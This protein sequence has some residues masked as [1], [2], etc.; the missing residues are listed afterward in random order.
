[1]K[2]YLK[3]RLSKRQRWLLR[4]LLRTARY[5][6]ERAIDIVC[7]PFLIPI[8]CLLRHVRLQLFRSPWFGFPVT[9]FTLRKIGV[10]PIVDHFYDPLFLKK[11]LAHSLCDDRP[12]PHIHFNHKEQIDLLAAFDYNQQLLDIPLEPSDNPMEYSYSVGPFGP[13]DSEYY[14]SMIRHFMPSNIVEIGSGAS[15][16]MAQI[17]IRHNAQ[18][19]SGYRCQYT[20]I[21]PFARPGIEDC[22]VKLQRQG[23]EHADPNIFKCLEANDILFIDSTHIIRPQGDVL[24]EYFQILPALKS[25][26]IVHVHDIFTPRDYPDEWFGK[27]LWNEMYLLESI[28]SWSNAFKI[29]GALNYLFHHHK[30]TLL[31]KCPVLK[32]HPGKEPASFWMIKN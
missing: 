13:G 24:F 14:Y 17:A 12:L 18:A 5:L 1:M 23:I 6:T 8:V 21:D 7:A 22:G 10:F 29:I 31:A 32:A 30:D 9:R 2:N 4:R 20:C 25:G 11:H 19:I 15:T 3:S 16:L 28:L 27:Y 26:V